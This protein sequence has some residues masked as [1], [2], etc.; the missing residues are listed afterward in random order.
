MNS[1]VNYIINASLV[2]C[3]CAGAFFLVSKMPA[4]TSEKETLSHIDTPNQSPVFTLSDSGAKGKTLFMSRCASCHALFKDMTGPGL[5]GFTEREPWTNRQNVYDWIRN[6]AAFMQ[7]NE[8]ARKLREAYN[9][10]LMTAFP[11]LT[12]G[13]IDAICDYVREAEQLYYLKSLP[14]TQ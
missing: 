7:K 11:N 4:S 6:P 5:V 1:Q 8:Y 13:E 12:N 14:A 2:L 3:V 9:G 10:M